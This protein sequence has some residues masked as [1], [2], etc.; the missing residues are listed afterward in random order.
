MSMP[1]EHALR[2]E[3]NLMLTL[4]DEF[5]KVRDARTLP[6]SISC[7]RLG[8]NPSEGRVRQEEMPSA[9]VET[10]L[11]ATAGRNRE[12]SEERQ[13][14]HC[15]EGH[16]RMCCREPKHAKWLDERTT[17]NSRKWNGNEKMHDEKWR[18]GTQTD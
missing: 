4:A 5:S 6:S 11:A 10:T 16:V 3:P 17:R 18:T 12:S 2:S 1:N 14:V 7:L 15:Q 9:T 13:S 8:T